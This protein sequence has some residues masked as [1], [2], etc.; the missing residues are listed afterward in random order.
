MGGLLGSMNPLNL[1]PFG[2][3]DEEKKASEAKERQKAIEKQRIA[4]S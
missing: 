4:G 1:M 3:D 2:S